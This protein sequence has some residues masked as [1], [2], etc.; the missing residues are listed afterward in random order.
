[1]DNVKIIENTRQAKDEYG[2]M[3]GSDTFYLTPEMIEALLNGKCIAGDDGVYV[4][5]IEME[6]GN[7]CKT[8]GYDRYDDFLKQYEE[9]CIKTGITISHED[10]QGA[11]ILENFNTENLRWMKDAI[12]K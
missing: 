10:S 3:F 11:F 2:Y 9:L 1:M 12:R 6:S 4:T 8:T 7:M 5:F